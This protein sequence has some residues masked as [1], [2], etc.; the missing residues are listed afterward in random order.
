[1]PKGIPDQKY[2]AEFK[3]MV[4]ETLQEEKPGYRETAQGK[5]F[6]ERSHGKFLW[7]NQKRAVSSAKV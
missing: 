7:P 4:I 3:K 2:T 1:M 5:L 6:G